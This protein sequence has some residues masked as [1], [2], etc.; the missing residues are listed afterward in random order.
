[1]EAAELIAELQKVPPDT[2]VYLHVPDRYDGEMTD[3]NLERVT[4]YPATA[5]GNGFVELDY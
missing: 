2:Q 1:M 5:S 4:Y 3:E